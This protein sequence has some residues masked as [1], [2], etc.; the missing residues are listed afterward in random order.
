M[1]FEFQSQQDADKHHHSSRIQRQ[2][3]NRPQATTATPAPVR[4]H[5]SPQPP[6][7]QDKD[8]DKADRLSLKDELG[9]NL[10]CRT[11]GRRLAESLRVEGESEGGLDAG[12]EGL[13][14][15]CVRHKKRLSG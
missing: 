9:A 13:R 1:H 8:E 7:P 2:Q 6:K 14:V 5:P 12:A 11:S 10:V 3:N 4:A 15:A